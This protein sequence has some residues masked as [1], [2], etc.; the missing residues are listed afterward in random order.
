MH[1]KRSLLIILMF[2]GIASF[3]Y[4]VDIGIE[5]FPQPGVK[6]IVDIDTSKASIPVGEYTAV[7]ATQNWDFSHSLNV[8]ARDTLKV[9]LPSE[10]AYAS[11]F[12]EADIVY[13]SS[14]ERLELPVTPPILDTPVDTLIRP[15]RFLRYDT[16]RM[17]GLGM[18]LVIPPAFQDAARFDEPSVAYDMPMEAGKTWLSFW[19]AD[20]TLIKKFGNLDIPVPVFVKDS[21][22]IEVDAEGVLT[23]NGQSFSCVRLKSQWRRRILV[24]WGE[25][26]VEVDNFGDERIIYQWFVPGTGVVLEIR[27]KRGE[28][29]SQFT[30]AAQITKA[31]RIETLTGCIDCEE[32]EPAVLPLPKSFHLS[33][34]FPN[35]FN[36]ATQINFQLASESVVSLTILNVLGQQVRSLIS[37]EQLNRGYHT[38]VWNGKS[39]VESP[40]PS[41]LYFYHIK[42]DPVD[43]KRRSIETKKMILNQ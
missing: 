15:V 11:I 8:A 23:L 38:A 10:T 6:V 2:L 31:T 29:N 13:I 40:L 27:S 36:N 20:T 34:N 14:I 32:N 22:N 33:Q 7:G 1:H 5:G 9:M 39:N 4:A 17:L 37:N 41:G 25:D 24:Q 28:T 12:P 3:A 42:V 16:N 21:S 43:G 26:L 19:E 30:E 35:P 18:E